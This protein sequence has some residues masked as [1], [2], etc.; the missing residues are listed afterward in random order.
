MGGFRVALWLYGGGMTT[1]AATWAHSTTRTDVHEVTRQLTV[2]LG[3]TLV[4]ALAGTPDRKLPIRWARPDGP[5]PGDAYQ[6][7]L[8]VAHRLWT[9]LSG[10]ESDHIARSWFIAANPLLG[11]D[12]PLTAIRGDRTREV[13]AAAT[14]FVE[15]QP[16]T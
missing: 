5:T 1:T 16:A 14:A 8:Q 3:P 13:V 6:R 11:E 10:A 15:D 7:R 4:A 2:H 9:Q 12:T